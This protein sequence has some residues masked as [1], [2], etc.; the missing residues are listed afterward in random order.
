MP[1]VALVTGGGHGMGRQHCLTLA[2][3]GLRVGVNDVDA[4]AAAETAAAVRGSGGEALAVPADVARRA[5]VEHAVAQLVE[6]WGG[7]DV[8]VSNAGTIHSG[9]GLLDTDDDDWNRT[10]GVHVGGCLNVSR[11]CMPWLLQRSSP[12]LIIIGSL[13]GQRGDGHSY[14]YAAA[15]GAVAA[16]A[17]NLAVEFGHAGLCVNVV[18]PGSVPTRM[19]AD[20]SE[21]DI[22]ED[23]LRIPLGRWGTTQEI[24]A[25]VAF[26]ASEEASYITGQ[27][28]AVNG[29]QVLTGS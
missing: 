29:G 8:A 7:I 9:T 16:F 15:K 19:A 26:L 25:V 17:R 6:T 12:R 23:C 22:A 3:R 27:M 5:E 28:I 18:A 20:Y 10:L 1:R 13:W 21:A 2:A 14:A 24:S 11:A 4:E